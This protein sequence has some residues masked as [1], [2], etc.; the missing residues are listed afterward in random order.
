MVTVP[1]PYQSG[2][3]GPSHHPSYQPGQPQGAFPGIGGPR[4]SGRVAVYLT[5]IAPL[6]LGMVMPLAATK[7]VEHLWRTNAIYARGS[8][9]VPLI[10]LA[11]LMGIAG[12]LGYL[13]VSGVEATRS[14]GASSSGAVVVGILIGTG[15][16]AGSWQWF[17][18]DFILLPFIP[19]AI[20]GFAIGLYALALCRSGRPGGARGL[21]QGPG[22]TAPNHW[23]SSSTTGQ[24]G[25][26]WTG[27]QGQQ[28]GQN[29]QYGQ[30]QQHGQQPGGASTPYG[31]SGSGNPFE[32]PGR[33]S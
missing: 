27:Q 26:G 1:N 23:Q 11:A 8:Y 15:F 21:Q 12:A 9:L 17:Q 14:R 28:H 5:G 29:Q 25:A 31:T 19:F 20:W 7:A 6:L 18:R 24:T 22:A 10:L 4:I 2:N 30:N 33:P 3:T 16:A 13:V 32:Y